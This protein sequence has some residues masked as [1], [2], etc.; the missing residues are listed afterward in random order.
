[1]NHAVRRVT[2]DG[3][4][5]SFVTGLGQPMGLAHDGVDKLFIA[6]FGMNAIYSAPAKPSDTGGALKTLAAGIVGQAGCVDGADG[7]TFNGPRN[8][9]LDNGVLFVADAL[10]DRIRSVL[11]T[12]GE[13]E[14]WTG[15]STTAA[16]P[17][18]PPTD[19]Y[20]PLELATFWEP[21]SL[22]GSTT[23]L[24]IADAKNHRI[25]FAT[26][27]QVST[28]TGSTAGSRDGSLAAAQFNEP[29]GITR[30]KNGLLYV[31][32]TLNH[33]IRIVDATK[34]NKV[35]T[36]AGKPPA[37][38]AVDGT[39]DV[40]TFNSPSGVAVDDDLSVYVG[41]T[42]NNRVRKIYQ[43]PPNELAVAWTAPA[44]PPGK[45]ID[46]YEVDAWAG[47]KVGSAPSSLG[48]K[49]KMPATSCIITGLT[50]GTT[51][52]ITVSAKVGG[53]TVGTSAPIPA[54]PQ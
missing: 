20:Q 9:L 6:D 29:R 23:A 2:P 34:T 54:T 38:G 53:A 30:D 8:L 22:A 1:M 26:A 28:L 37:S 33:A 3:E 44:N 49:P 46:G 5:S 19:G 25:R 47:D 21:S 17:G 52:T 14:S 36:L 35:I 51:Y 4:V 42:G 11:I 7:G 12:T 40:A 18:T 48:C 50:R 13:V 41:D 39:P 24:Y 10:N 16:T 31:A 27:S 32:D 15:R 43:R 45:T